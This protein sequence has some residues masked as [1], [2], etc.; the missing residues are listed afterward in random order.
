MPIQNAIRDPERVSK[1]HQQLNHEK[2]IL[3]PKAI[4]N[5]EILNLKQG[6]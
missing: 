4:L 6:R 3:I 5:H 1:G 2:A